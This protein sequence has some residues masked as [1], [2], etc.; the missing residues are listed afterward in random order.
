LFSNDSNDYFYHGRS[1]S[2]FSPSNYATNLVD[3]F[4]LVSSHYEK[5]ENYLT[6]A[7]NDDYLSEDESNSSVSDDSDEEEDENEDDDSDDQ[8][9]ED[10]DDEEEI[11]GERRCKNQSNHQIID[12]ETN[13]DE[14]DRRSHYKVI[15]E[16]EKTLEF[17]KNA[18]SL[19]VM[20]TNQMTYSACY[21][22]SNSFAT[23]TTVNG[24]AA[25][26]ALLHNID[27]NYSSLKTAHMSLSSLCYDQQTSM[28]NIDSDNINSNQSTEEDD[29]SE[30]ETM[31]TTTT[32]TTD[33]SSSSE[34]KL[35]S[36]IKRKSSKIYSQLKGLNLIINNSIDSHMLTNSFDLK[37]KTDN[38]LYANKKLHKLKSEQQ[39]AKKNNIYQNINPTANN[40]NN[41]AQ[42]EKFNLPVIKINGLVNENNDYEDCYYSDD[43]MPMSLQPIITTTTTITNREM[44]F[45]ELKVFSND[46]ISLDPSKIADTTILN[47]NLNVN[48][49]NVNSTP[50]FSDANSASEFLNK[51]KQFINGQLNLT[52]APPSTG[53]CN[54]T[55]LPTTPSDPA[56]LVPKVPA[57]YQNQQ[58]LTINSVP[59]SKTFSSTPYTT[60][61]LTTET[62]NLKSKSKVNMLEVGDGGSKVTGSLNLSRISAFNSDTT[63][64]TVVKTQMPR[65]LKK[66]LKEELKKDKKC[67]IQ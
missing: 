19:K 38:T 28:T 42:P 47:Q 59:K 37:P 31:I 48:N 61:P 41:E 46:S 35:R 60:N 34:P 7:N 23:T 17:V 64:V 53:L 49:F 39:N 9:N 56:F 36:I 27:S 21:S 14:H 32:T 30:K 3:D 15:K 43:Q 65:D 18:S 5:N 40:A 10:E 24:R 25:E 62:N 12:Q 55:G 45:N 20:N 54:V 52:I 33:P 66:C 2:K 13:E 51:R 26:A 44:L 22:Q 8:E 1:E 6:T 63:M 11:E 4:Y 50:I 29:N 16:F 57:I 58:D 67:V